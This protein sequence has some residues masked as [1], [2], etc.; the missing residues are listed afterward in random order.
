MQAC[1][2]RP[3]QVVASLWRWGTP[4]NCRSAH[5][6]PSRQ[7]L[8]LESH[9]KSREQQLARHGGSVDRT[10]GSNS[11]TSDPVQIHKQRLT[12]WFSHMPREEKQ[13]GELFSPVAMHV[14]PLIVEAHPQQHGHKVTSIK[15]QALLSQQQPLSVAQLFDDLTG[16]ELK[17]GQNVVLYGGVGTGKSTVVQKLVLDWCSGVALSQFGLVIPFSCEDLSVCTQAI[18]LR[19]L[20]ARKYLH[21]RD[22]PQLRGDSTSAHDVLFIFNG[23]EQMKLDF[24]ISSTELCNNPDEPLSAAGILVNLLRKYLLPEASILVTSRMSAL[25]MVP[26]KYVNHYVQIRGFG[27][28]EQQRAYFTSRL[29]HGSEELMSLLYMNLQRESQLAAACFLPSYCWLTCAI[30]HFLHFTDSHAPLCSLT[31]IY[32]GFLRLNFAGEILVAGASGPQQSISLMRY[33]VKTVGKVAYEGI[34]AKKT[35]FTDEELQEWLD[36]KSQ[37]DEELQQLGVLRTD[38]LDFFIAHRLDGNSDETRHVFVIP[39]MQEYLAALYVVLGEKKTVLE[40]LGKEVSEAI[41]QVSEDLTT[42]LNILAKFLPLRVFAFFNLLKMFPSLYRRISGRSKGSIGH[43]MAKEMF[44]EEDLMNEDVLDQVEQSLLGVQGPA[45]R[46]Q[47]T[48][49]SFELFPIFM[50]GLLAH[51]NRVLLEHMGCNI[52]SS[53]VIQIAH[54]LKKHLISSSQKKLPPEEL[55]DFLF[56]LYEF[57]NQ[58]FTAEVLRSHSRLNLSSV[59]M[60]PL[61]CFVLTSVMSTL[62]PTHLLD[63]L[64]LSSCHLTPEGLLTL[65]PVLLRCRNVNLQF[66]N[67]HP[68]ACEHIRSIL[69]DS[70]CAIQSLHLCDNPLAEEGA[71]ILAETLVGSHSLKHLSLMHTDLGD[72]GAIAL[73]AHLKDNT[74]LEE[75]N[76]A[77]NSICDHA[78]LKLVEACRDHPTLDRVHLYLNPVSETGKLALHSASQGNQ[79]KVKM[80]VSVTQGENVSEYWEV[81]LNIVK[82]NSATWDRA[83]VQEH[84]QLFLRDLEG[85]RRTSRSIWKKGHFRRVEREV[86]DVLRR[87][88]HD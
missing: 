1:V 7:T 80:L 56:F 28:I 71:R 18:S 31:G 29:G 13:F 55:V 37:T 57:Q 46:E 64:D 85:G 8:R 50:G 62:P 87:L 16:S 84:L 33:V 59:R 19:K 25:D 61:K 24:R 82:K 47:Q 65:L 38:V 40:V 14:D 54:T 60:T 69:L 10:F 41:G 48:K 17:H 21:L 58:S 39:T 22:V 42:L 51:S 6:K 75:L 43:T 77:Y 12:L 52:K 27:D 9:G 2:W 53:S 35:S 4:L 83:R 72:G 67:L 44:K 32:T 15:D 3:P 26:T 73:A 30:L 49:D 20:V 63:E 79:G 36:T 81:I 68:V 74:G 5:F 11:A 78:S 86:R 70:N 45:P 88:G 66:N 23:L 76:V 34:R